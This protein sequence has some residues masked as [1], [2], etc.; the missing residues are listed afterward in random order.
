MERTLARATIS[1]RQI[2]HQRNAA[3]MHSKSFVMTPRD[4][5]HFAGHNY[6]YETGLSHGLTQRIPEY[7]IPQISV[8]P[9]NI[10]FT[11]R[12]MSISPKKLNPITPR[13]PTHFDESGARPTIFANHNFMFN[14]SKM[15]P[16]HFGIHMT[17][18]QELM[19]SSRTNVSPKHLRSPSNLSSLPT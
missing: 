7:E 2:R 19:P 15:T 13:K 9:K 14:I 17:T 6:I 16:S 3:T 8:T 11:P 10:P 5:H 12:N 18:P 1:N 4:S